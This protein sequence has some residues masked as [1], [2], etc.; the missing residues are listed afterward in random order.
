MAVIFVF[1]SSDDL[2]QFAEKQ[3]ESLS[4]EERQ[5]FEQ[6]NDCC[7]FET[8]AGS[9]CIGCYDKIQDQLQAHLMIIGWVCI[10]IFI[11]QIGLVFFGCCL[12]K[13]LPPSKYSQINTN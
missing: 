4:E 5:D 10:A 6:N 7:G 8:V 11:Y 2:Q 3:W 9:D 12:C 13:K 1:T